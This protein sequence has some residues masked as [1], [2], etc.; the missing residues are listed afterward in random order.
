[1]VK[2]TKATPKWNAYVYCVS[3]YQLFCVVSKMNTF[4]RVC[5]CVWYVLCSVIL[6]FKPN[7]S[8]LQ[9]SYTINKRVCVCVCINL[10]LV[11]NYYY[12]RALLVLLPL[13]PLL[14]GYMMSSYFS[15]I[16][17]LIASTQITTFYLL[18]T[19]KNYRV[20][21]H[22]LYTHTRSECG[23]FHKRN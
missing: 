12:S 18:R 16:I 13:L 5:V 10:H 7:Y 14:H 9:F 3:V 20:L 6:Q 23:G 4:V 8:T 19:K 11:W 21:D 1:M 22:I 17:N 2:K 15:I